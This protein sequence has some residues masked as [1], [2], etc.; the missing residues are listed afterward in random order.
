MV[1]GPQPDRLLD[2]LRHDP[3]LT[4][5]IAQGVLAERYE[6][7]RDLAR[8]LLEHRAQCAGLQVVEA[9]RWLLV[10]GCLP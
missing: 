1:N 5:A 8:W 2:A 6:V 9:A 4:V 10:A 3:V 7:D